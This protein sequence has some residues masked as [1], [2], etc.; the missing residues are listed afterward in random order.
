MLFLHHSD[1]VPLLFHILSSAEAELLVR[2]V[3]K[4]DLITSPEL[5]QLVS[6]ILTFKLNTCIVCHQSASHRCQH[7]RLVKYCCRDHQATDWKAS[8]KKWCWKRE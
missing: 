4:S 1:A 5:R 3:Q 6:M 7:C 8:H 2:E